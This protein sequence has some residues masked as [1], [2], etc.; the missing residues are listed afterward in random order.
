MIS[1]IGKGMW[2]IISRGTNYVKAQHPILS[3]IGSND[4][5]DLSSS[6]TTIRSN[7]YVDHLLYNSR[8]HKT[9]LSLFFVHALLCHLDGGN[10]AISGET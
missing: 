8:E 3:R 1:A 7:V 2:P 10:E 9:L 6:K 5:L 4:S